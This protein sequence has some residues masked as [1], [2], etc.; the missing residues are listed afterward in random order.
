MAPLTG[1][2]VDGTSRGRAQGCS[3]HPGVIVL[4]TPSYLSLPVEYKA[5]GRRNYKRS[6]EAAIVAA[7]PDESATL[8]AGI[9]G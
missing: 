8:H 3:C 5:C 7:D 4:I 9:G 6:F 2:A 1:Y